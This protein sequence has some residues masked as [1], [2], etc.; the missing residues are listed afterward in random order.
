MPAP[1]STITSRVRS[2]RTAHHAAVAAL[3]ER[4]RQIVEEHMQQ[5]LVEQGRAEL[6][7]RGQ[8]PGGQAG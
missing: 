7:H 3:Q 6:E 8:P 4:Q 2:G 1:R 5:R